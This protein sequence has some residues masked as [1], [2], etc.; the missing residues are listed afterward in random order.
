MSE[1]DWAWVLTCALGAVNMAVHPSLVSQAIWGGLILLLFIFRA[2]RRGQPLGAAEATTKPAD[3]VRDMLAAYQVA[4]FSEEQAR[5]LAQEALR[6][7]VR[8]QGG[9]TP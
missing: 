1:L 7:E 2:A 3:G 9:W 8:K 6:T 5:E 4:G